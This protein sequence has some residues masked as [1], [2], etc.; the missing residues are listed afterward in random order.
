MPSA[1]GLFPNQPEPSKHL[2]LEWLKSSGAFVHDGIEIYES[3]HGWGVRATRD[4]EFDE[5][6]MSPL[7]RVEAV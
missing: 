6:R 4:V 3:D 7:S 1:Q 5:L 2:L